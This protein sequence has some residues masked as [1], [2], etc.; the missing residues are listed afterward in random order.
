M[1]E[2]SHF[3]IDLSHDREKQAVM[4]ALPGETVIEHQHVMGLAPPF[5]DQRGSGPQLQVS[6]YRGRS[7][8]LEL[9][10]NPAELALPRWAEA[11]QREFLHPVCGSSYEQL[12]AEVRGA[13][14]FCREHATADEV[15]RCRA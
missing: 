14:E 15:R 2:R 5:P 4:R 12:A 1:G 6:P 7:S 13:P 8:F 10:C 9:L 11:A 3:N